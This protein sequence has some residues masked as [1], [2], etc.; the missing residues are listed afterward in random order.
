MI[1][2]S[3]HKNKANLINGVT[4]VLG[5]FIISFI[6]PFAEKATSTISLQPD[7]TTS[8]VLGIDIYVKRSASC[9]GFV[10]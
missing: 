5:T 3:I 9:R 8:V 7:Y 6:R 10:L 1:K 2:K 4:L